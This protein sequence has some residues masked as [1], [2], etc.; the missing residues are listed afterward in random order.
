MGVVNLI[1]VLPAAG[2]TT[3]KGFGMPLLSQRLR[4]MEPDL[5]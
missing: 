1:C 5:S 2:R 3:A 4:D